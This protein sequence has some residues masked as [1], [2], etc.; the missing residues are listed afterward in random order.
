MQFTGKERDSETGL[1]WFDVRYLSS[2][3]GRFTSPD[4][5]FAD[6][7]LDDPQ[8]WNLYSYGRN[9]PLRNI[10]PSGRSCV[11]TTTPDGQTQQ[12][13]D[14]DGKGCTPAGV[15]PTPNQQPPAQDDVSDITPQ[16]TNADAKATP[17]P[18][19]QE[20]KRQTDRD[21]EYLVRQTLDPIERVK[22]ATIPTPGPKFEA[23]RKPQDPP[24]ID[25]SV[26]KFAPGFF[27]ENSD[28]FL[29]KRSAPSDPLVGNGPGPY[30]QPTGRTRNGGQGEVGGY[31]NGPAG[32]AEFVNYLSNLQQCKAAL[33]G[34]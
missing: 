9:N 32:A 34:Q 1:D 25:A 22:H 19:S 17:V 7:R 12:G 2:A 20:E 10:D 14:G 5:P 26:C 23:P 31:G 8:S 24:H 6:Q 18:G 3:Q 4:L 27:L 13:D 21:L 11:T 30:W 16:T 33:A 15:A 28:I 29:G